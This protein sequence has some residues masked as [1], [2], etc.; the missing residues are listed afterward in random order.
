MT[1]QTNKQFNIYSN[2]AQAKKPMAR[3][4]KAAT[5]V[6]DLNRATDALVGVLRH[7]GKIKPEQE[8]E[9]LLSPLTA[10]SM[11]ADFTYADSE[12]NNYDRALNAGVISVAAGIVVDV[13][14]RHSVFSASHES[15]QDVRRTASAPVKPSYAP[16]R[17]PTWGAR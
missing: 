12:S 11:A 8:N 15:V 1:I 4:F 5:D 16:G 2:L 14:E 13:I 3:L 6:D 17:R 7:F 9:A 10:L